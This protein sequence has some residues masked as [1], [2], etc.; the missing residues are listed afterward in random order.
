MIVIVKRL[1]IV[2]TCDFATARKTN[3]IKE[4]EFY[5][6][7][8]ILLLIIMQREMTGN[9]RASQVRSFWILSG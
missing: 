5:N 6:K 9:A 2:Q 3:L 1:S 7:I 8:I 4:A